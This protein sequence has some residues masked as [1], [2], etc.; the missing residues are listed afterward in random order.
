MR[1]L[2]LGEAFDARTSF[3]I[4][5]Q[6]IGYYRPVDGSPLAIGQY[7]EDTHRQTAGADYPMGPVNVW[8]WKATIDPFKSPQP[9]FESQVARWAR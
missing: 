9:L 3:A 4:A 2:L 8:N 1:P 6:P 5:G 7:W